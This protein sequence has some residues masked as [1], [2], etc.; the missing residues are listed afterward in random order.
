[1]WLESS[2]YLRGTTKNPYNL[3]RYLIKIILIINI[4]SH[5]TFN[6]IYLM[7]LMNYPQID[8]DFV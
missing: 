6:L 1:M 2:N 8:L 5:Y 3:S 7:L 4:A